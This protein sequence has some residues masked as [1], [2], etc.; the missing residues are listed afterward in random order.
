M[1][2]VGAGSECRALRLEDLLQRRNAP[3]A[4]GTGLA[5]VADVV[6]AGGARRANT[7]SND[8][9]GHG[10]AVTNDHDVNVARLRMTINIDLNLRVIISIDGAA[11]SRNSSFVSPPE[12]SHGSA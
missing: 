11:W 12:P 10:V 7:G 6:H 5:E 9:V 2:R 4:A 8:S 3:P 1:R